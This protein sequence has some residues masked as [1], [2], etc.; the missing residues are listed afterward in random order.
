MGRDTLCDKGAAEIRDDKYLAWLVASSR[1]CI[2]SEMAEQLLDATIHGCK[3][4]LEIKLGEATFMVPCSQLPEAWANLLHIYCINDYQVGS[5]VSIEPGNTVVDGGAYLGFF[6]VRAAL[7]MQRDGLVIAVEPNPLARRA[8]YRNLELNMLE[9][10][11]RVDPRALSGC[12]YCIRKIYVTE[13]WVNTTTYSYY[14]DMMGNELVKTLSIPA[15]G[16]KKLLADH[17]VGFIDLLKLDIEGAEQEVLEHAVEGGVL[18]PSA[19]RQVIV[20]VHPPFTDP[21]GIEALLRD[22]G[23]KTIRKV[24]GA[25][26][27]QAI[28]IGVS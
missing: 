19:V 24:L 1:G 15:I 14:V 25:K 16:L 13:P 21:A 22:Q 10:V 18:T 17:G 5:L 23:Y 20:E 4:E 8:L 26:W 6:T 9:N 28:V 27:M 3:G 11:A 12:E 7:A 2:G